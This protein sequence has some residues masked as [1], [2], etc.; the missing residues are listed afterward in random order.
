MNQ[1][2]EMFQCPGTSINSGPSSMLSSQSAFFQSTG[3]YAS[4]DTVP[5]LATLKTPATQN[6]YPIHT[7]HQCV[8]ST[9]PDSPGHLW[10]TL[11][12]PASAPP[13]QW[14]PPGT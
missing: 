12:P 13:V 9:S 4:L 1:R 14:V 7:V 8:V 11:P 10:Q 3:D 6:D 2:V 5:G